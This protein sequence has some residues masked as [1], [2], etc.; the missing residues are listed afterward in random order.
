MRFRGQRAASPFPASRLACRVQNLLI[1]LGLCLTASACGPTL[2]ETHLPKEAVEAEREKQREIAF[3][4]LMQRQ[5][6]L[7]NVSY[8][9]LVAGAELCKDEARP[10]SGF[11][12]HDKK[13]YQTTL[14]REY[15]QVAARQYGLRDQVTVRYVHPAL[16]AASAGLR[17]GDRV[18]TINGQP[19]AD[20][21]AIEATAMLDELGSS[22]GR[23]IQLRIERDG[24]VQELAIQGAPA[25][26]YPV[27]LINEDAVNAFADGKRVVITTGM[28]RFAE[29]D[30]ELA[31]VV[32]HEVAHNALGHVTKQF[33]NVLLGTVF[34]VAFA[35][36]LGVDTQG[37][38]GRL[39]G[40]AFSQAFEA[41]AD[42]AGLYIV[43]RA[44][45][46]VSNA[47]NF[48]RRMAVEHPGSIKKNFLATHP[49]TPERFLAI[50][51]TVREIDEKR[52]Q[53][54]PLVPEKK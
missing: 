30:K 53:G 10:T 33:G 13:L 37:L 16:P 45:Y 6:R 14:G 2:K 19:V 46:D 23:P 27:Q 7:L 43:A 41:E 24:R 12:L 11:T 29:S 8:P 21:T 15:E 28:V 26:K 49:S 36:L 18:L 42:Y 50:E 1:V 9:L 38:F 34:D 44:G 17:A 39:G 47:A 52:R 32:G 35:V 3:S 48:W 25:C 5:D 54:K 40:R 51:N 20:K 22:E 31:L 4:V